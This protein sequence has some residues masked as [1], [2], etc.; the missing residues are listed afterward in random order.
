LREEFIVNRAVAVIAQCQSWMHDADL[1][2]PHL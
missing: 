2:H 1:L